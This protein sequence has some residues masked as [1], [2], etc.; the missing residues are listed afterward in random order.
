M[1]VIAAGWLWS[2]EQQTKISEQR[3]PKNDILEGLGA[4]K[5]DIPTLWKSL[6]AGI[7][8]FFET[9]KEKINELKSSSTTSSEIIFEKN[10]T[11]EPE[12]PAEA[13]PIE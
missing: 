12:S 4:A 8:S 9:A 5:S 11:S 13:L 2:F 7:S 6:G 3:A 10:S 1:I